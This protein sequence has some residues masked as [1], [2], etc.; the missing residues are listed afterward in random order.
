MAIYGFQTKIIGRSSGRSTIT[1]ASHNT[2]KAA[3]AIRAVAYRM[4]ESLYDER[5]GET[6][7]YARK[8]GGNGS[9]L[10][11]PT[12]APD[13]LRNRQTLWNEVERSERRKDAQLARDFILTLPYELTHQ[14]HR[15]LIR[16]YV[17]V[18]FL[19]TEK[20]ADVAIT[21]MASRYRPN[22]QSFRQR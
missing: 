19:S 8:F 12:D 16:E 7:S 21:L 3:S 17:T 6:H 9:D 15:A 5:T 20:I 10:F 14:Q 2:G 4:R 1:S 18:H 11:L 22:P 13:R